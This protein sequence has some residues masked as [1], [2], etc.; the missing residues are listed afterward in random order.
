MGNKQKE[1]ELIMQQENCDTVATMETR[2][3]G[4]H[5]WD[6]AMQPCQPDIS[7]REDHGADHV[8]CH[9][10]EH[11]GQAGGQAPRAMGLWKAGPAD[12]SVSSCDRVTCPVDEGKVVDVSTWTLQ[13]LWHHF[14]QNSPG[15]NARGLDGCTVH[16]VKKLSG[17]L[18]P[19]SGGAWS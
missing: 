11:A 8:E 17:W 4:L 2:R 6:I 16:W 10:M 14:T 7:A 19:V 3:G 1:Q 12:Q 15:E 9:Q 18:D 5:N 13:I